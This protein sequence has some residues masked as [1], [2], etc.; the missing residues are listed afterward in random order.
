MNSLLEGVGTWDCG[1]HLILLSE[2]AA[3]PAYLMLSIPIHTENAIP[4]PS[5]VCN[6]CG[7]LPAHFE[8]FI[9]VL[10]QEVTMFLIEL[11][12]VL[13]IIAYLIR[14]FLRKVW[15]CV[16]YPLIFIS[17]TCPIV[18]ILWCERLYTCRSK[19]F[20]KFCHMSAGHQKGQHPRKH[21]LRKFC[22]ICF[23]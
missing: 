15:G 18:L 4:S 20:E 5:H 12:L 6:P 1:P 23:T 19:P 13:N 14:I 21:G 11:R 8:K 9:T 3:I 7:A 10:G 22:Q 2:E 17:F 16:R